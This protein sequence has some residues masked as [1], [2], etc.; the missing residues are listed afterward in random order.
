MELSAEVEVD[1]GRPRSTFSAED[2]AARVDPKCGEVNP[3][4]V[5]VFVIVRV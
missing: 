4:D 1:C 2:D 5:R 3:E